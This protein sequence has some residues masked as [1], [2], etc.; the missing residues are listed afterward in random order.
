MTGF[1]IHIAHLTPDMLGQ[2]FLRFITVSDIR[3]E[4]LTYRTVD[5][6][7]SIDIFSAQY[8]KHKSK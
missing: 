2:S 7:A 1:T 6:I 8:S 4:E 3:S 5:G